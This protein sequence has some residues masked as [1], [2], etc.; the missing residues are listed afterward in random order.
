MVTKESLQD[1]IDADVACEASRCEPLFTKRG[2]TFVKNV[3]D[4]MNRMQIA[5]CDS[6]ALQD[7]NP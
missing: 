3:I 4:M 7:A 1:L 5:R 6:R 2:R